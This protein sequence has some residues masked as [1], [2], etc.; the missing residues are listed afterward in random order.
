MRAGPRPAA[1]T[2]YASTAEP[3]PTPTFFGA[4]L[5]AFNA[6]EAARCRSAPRLR[7]SSHPFERRGKLL[8][9]G[10][11]GYELGALLGRCSRISN[12]SSDLHA[13]GTSRQTNEKRLRT[14]SRPSAWSGR[15]V[16]HS[17]N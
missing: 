10:R 7:G 2:N 16:E 1:V 13:R 12:L 15:V 8:E 3:S 11:H 4:S 5:S 14:G 17:S 6:C 9:I